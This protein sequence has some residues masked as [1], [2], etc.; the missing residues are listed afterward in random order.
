[1]NPAKSSIQSIDLDDLERKL[2]NFVDPA[3]P[4]VA[5]G[6]DQ[7]GARTA[8]VENFRIASAS[9][10]NSMGAGQ[11]VSSSEGFP[12][13]VW[14]TGKLPDLDAV[15]KQLREV[16]AAVLDKPAAASKKGDEAL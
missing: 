9:K 11:S 8:R 7:A 15:E 16:A 5:S 13:P 4:D 14:A 1:M 2:R 3:S 6:G 10:P 12:R